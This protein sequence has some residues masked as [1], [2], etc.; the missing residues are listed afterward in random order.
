MQTQKLEFENAIGDILAARLDL[1][2][3]EE[4]IAYAL[5]AHCFTCSKNLTAV[6]RISRALNRQRIAVLRFDFTGL[7]ESEGEFAETNFTSNIGDLVSAARFLEQRFQA[8]A[9]LIGH[10]LGGA[11]VLRAAAEIPS[12]R[13]VATIAAPYDPAHITRLFRGSLDTIES[14]GE[15]TIDIGGRSL[16]ITR[17]LVRDLERTASE[18]VLRGLGRALMVLHSPAD[19]SVPLE[20]AAKI[21]TAAPHPKSFI[22]LD[23][24]DHLL[25]NAED[26]SY[27]G[28]VLSAWAMRYIESPPPPETLEQLKAEDR[29]VAR[30]GR[31]GYSTEIT[32]RGHSLVADEPTT[33]GGDDLGPTPYDLL[34]AALGACTTMTLRMYADRKEWPLEEVTARLRHSKIHA[35]DEED[36]GTAGARLDHIEREVSLV[37]ALDAEQRQRLLEIAERCPVHKSLTAGVDVRT[38]LA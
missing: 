27:V 31:E 9:L 29:V 25:T 11:A 7:G 26:A 8:P 10:S 2:A 28:S 1:P 12:A 32:T 15:A 14:R 37:G 13:A 17:Q 4:P 16:R 21:Y 35:K 23:D 24:A 6:V 5:F 36:V 38:T 19:E 33:V 18:G 20:N 34:V 30:T 3:G 22:S